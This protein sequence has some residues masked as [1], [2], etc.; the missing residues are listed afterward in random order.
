[1]S[2]KEARNIRC[3]NLPNRP[4][5]PMFFLP[6]VFSNYMNLSG[7]RVR[8][9]SAGLRCCHARDRLCICCPSFPQ[10]TKI[11]HKSHVFC[12]YFCGWG[13]DH[14]GTCE[15]LCRPVNPS[16]FNCALVVSALHN[17]NFPQETVKRFDFQVCECP[18]D[19]LV[20]VMTG[21]KMRN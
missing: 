15:N 11:L 18:R 12:S 16:A 8:G 14:S 13:M 5:G 2:A 7:E 6:R 3:H 17:F 10:K 4:A 20:E 19:Q 21:I 9:L 1:M